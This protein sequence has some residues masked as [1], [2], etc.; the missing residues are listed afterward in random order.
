MV[1][2]GYTLDQEGDQPSA[3]CDSSNAAL[4][5]AASALVSL[6]AESGLESSV[7]DALVQHGF[8]A[9]RAWPMRGFAGSLE[10]AIRTRG[11]D[12]LRQI[13]CSDSCTVE[14]E[15]RIP[16]LK[17]LWTCSVDSLRGFGKPAF[18]TTFEIEIKQHFD[19][20]YVLLPKLPGRV[21]SAVRLKFLTKGRM[22]TLQ[23]WEILGTVPDLEYVSMGSLQ[24]NPAGDRLS[25]DL[26]RA[27]RAESVL[28]DLFLSGR[29]DLND[30]LLLFAADLVLNSGH[31]ELARK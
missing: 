15:W 30:A 22:L 19:T 1:L 10:S 12:T 17:G 6:I 2:L 7:N 3:T 23:M 25:G 8:R 26:I 31:F 4:A 5:G 27:V 18:D 29:I 11:L 9:V 28:V 16:I 20:T 24:L 21:P 13:R 14:E